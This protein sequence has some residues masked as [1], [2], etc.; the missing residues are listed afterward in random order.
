MP[1]IKQTNEAGEEV[2]VDVFTPEEVDAKVKERE[3]ALKAE[4]EK[5]LG[6]KEA[7]IAN[8][9]KEKDE[10]ANKMGDIKPD[11]PNFKA[12]KEA[13]D[14]KDADIKALG[15][16]FES[17]EKQR[18]TEVMDAKIKAVAK[19]D[20]ELEKKMRLHLKD[21]LAGM[22]EGTEEERKAKLEAAFKLSSDNSSDG[23][24]MFDEG[25]GGGQG[26]GDMKPGE[27]GNEF[28]S[29]ER[30]LGAK[31]GITPEDY[32]KYGPRVSKKK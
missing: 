15:D 32:K 1:K 6:E 12:L 20:A 8:L 4:H 28:S 10:I 16:K 17:S 7:A 27:S 11:H 19:G 25:I 3:E 29:R 23:P 14:K 18:Q 21:T 9:Q 22:K 30:A 5:A 31:L 13:L 2:E 24:G 26:G